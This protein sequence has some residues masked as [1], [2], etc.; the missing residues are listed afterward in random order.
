MLVTVRARCMPSKSKRNQLPFHFL[1][2]IPRTC[3]G[4]GMAPAGHQSVAAASECLCERG[5]PHLEKSTPE[6]HRASE[7]LQTPANK[8]VRNVPCE[9]QP[10]G[11]A[12]EQ[13]PPPARTR[14]RCPAANLWMLQEAQQHG[15][16]SE[17]QRGCQQC[18]AS[19]CPQHHSE[20]TTSRAAGLP[21]L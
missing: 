3:E 1:P 2:V 13:Q 15:S 14:P 5:K 8:S 12:P 10:C 7:L 11:R 6:A 17:L 20:L 4:A 18:V 19:S 16:S 9:C 21:T